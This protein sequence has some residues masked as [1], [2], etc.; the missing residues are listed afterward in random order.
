MTKFQFGSAAV[1]T[2]NKCALTPELHELTISRQSDNYS[3][4]QYYLTDYEIESL[5]QNLLT[6]I[7]A[8]TT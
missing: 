1:L 5:S 2:V 7:N 6:Y 4:V 3:S 8:Q